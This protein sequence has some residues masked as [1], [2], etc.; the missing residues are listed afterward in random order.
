[1][2]PHVP[3]TAQEWFTVAELAEMSLPGLPT[4]KR[5]VQ[6]IAERE[7]WSMTIDGEGMA[8]SR[9][10]KGRGGGVE[11]HLSLLPDAARL[12]LSMA[13]PAQTGKAAPAQSRESVWK[14]YGSLSP[15][16]QAVAKRRL[17]L[18]QR[19]EMLARGLGKVQAVQEVVAGLRREA[20]AAKR[21]PEVSESTL[22]GWFRLIRLVDVCDRVAYLAP[23][24]QGRS[25]GAECTPAAWQF[26]KDYYLRFAGPTVAAAFTKTVEIGEPLGWV[27]P[28][29]KTIARW[30]KTRINRSVRILLREGDDALRRELPWIERDETTFHAME[31]VNVDGHKWD[32]IVDW[33]DGTK[34]DRPMMIMIQD[35]Y[36]RR[37]LGWHLCRSENAN[38]V[39]KVFAEVFKNH[40]IPRLCFFDNGRAFASK[41][42]TGGSAHRFRFAIREDDQVGLLVQL[43]VEVHFTTPYSGQSKPIERSFRDLEEHIGTHPAFQGA[44]VGNNPLH[45]PADAGERTVDIEEFTRIVADGIQRHNARLGRATKA[46]R[47]KLSFDQAYAESYANAL[48]PRATPEQLRQAM[49]CVEGLKVRQK[50]EGL[51]LAGNR[52]WGDFLIEHVGEK[53]AA[54][55][56]AEDLHAGLHVYSLGGVYLGFA[57]C[58]DKVGFANAEEGRERKKQQRRIV[59]AVAHVASLERQM[60]SDELVDLM[61]P[62]ESAEELRSDLPGNVVPGHFPKV[63]QPAAAPVNTDF[64]EQQDRTIALFR[65]S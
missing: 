52:Y 45:K 63:L 65:R 20:R 64:T 21:E 30:V 57:E 36:S 48:V 4:T 43:G 12:K 1:M 61:R 8:C 54:R 13:M 3:I 49:L 33:R 22:Y 53:I 11:Y 56:D 35:L 46:C 41:W 39:R 60:L 19:V 16:M 15:S 29:E 37:V 62:H 26:F 40:G 9:P 47:K 23:A 10:R 50:G 58:W 7:D 44:Y 2:S 28:S 32:V 55:F 5:G 34:P 17:E 42:L 24:Y 31:A 25:A 6:M 27:L 14:R 59:K 38:A 18:I 51:I